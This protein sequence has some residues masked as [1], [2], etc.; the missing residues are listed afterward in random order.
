MHS[1]Q[2]F[3][4][5]PFFPPACL[6]GILFLY[7]LLTFPALSHITMG[8]EGLYAY[9]SSLF[10]KGIVPYRDFFHSH[11]PAQLLLLTP[12]TM[13]FGYSPTILNAIPL[14]ASIL[15]GIL[16]FFLAKREWGTLAGCIAC[17]SF[18]FSSRNLL[19]SLHL[20]GWNETTALTV[21]G[22]FFFSRGK[23]LSAGIA[24]G[25]GMMFSLVA[26]VPSVILFCFAISQ[27]RWSAFRFLG[28][29]L[30]ILFI[31]QIPFLLVAGAEYG[32]Q[33]Y[34]FH[35]FKNP[36]GI[37]GLPFM[38]L[39]LAFVREHLFLVVGAILAC[40]LPFSLKSMSQKQSTGALWWFSFCMISGIGGFLLLLA[41]PFPQYFLI[42]TPFLSLLTAWSIAAAVQIWKEGRSALSTSLL[43]AL[44]SLAVL[45]TLRAGMG[46]IHST[47]SP[48]GDFRIGYDIAQYLQE[49]T[50]L[51]GTLYGDFGIA[52]TVALLSGR[53]IAAHEL[54]ST[55][56]RFDSG[57]ENFEEVIAALEADK[58]SVIILS[59][60]S[61][62][63]SFKPF[64]D[65][66]TEN[67]ILE[68]VFKDGEEIVEVWQRAH[69]PLSLGERGQG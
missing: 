18:L 47:S 9:A 14:S 10:A 37:G 34:L 30:A 53:R 38:I 67:F 66:L 40:I 25:I 44:F 28:G 42:L 61:M 16:L 59:P 69:V 6:I 5:Y 11:P 13:F 39:F 12:F 15:T 2:S 32:E 58:L 43:I 52:P 8:D 24:T 46:F 23:S 33:V 54:E 65:Y 55:P 68:A 26:V 50:S 31:L 19:H 1:K 63:R 41:R 21:L 20:T 57:K 27:S 49:K 22:V 7:A 29:F 4:S 56:M 64:T 62:M 3:L 45:S 35:L 60:E 48:Q 51:G 36:D 17:A